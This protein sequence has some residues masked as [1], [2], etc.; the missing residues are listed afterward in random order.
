[1]WNLSELDASICLACERA[2]VDKVVNKRVF[3][4]SQVDDNHPWLE[5][6]QHKYERAGIHCYCSS[7]QTNKQDYHWPN[8]HHRD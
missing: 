3:I 4:Q 8:R 1:M 7:A 5:C 6:I 2:I